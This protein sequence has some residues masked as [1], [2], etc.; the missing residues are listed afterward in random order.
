MLTMTYTNI[1]KCLSVTHYA[2]TSALCCN[3]LWGI[4]GPGHE[5]TVIWLCCSHQAMI[6]SPQEIYHDAWGHFQ[7]SQ[8]KVL[9]S[10]SCIRGH[11]HNKELPHFKC[12]YIQVLD[13]VIH[14]VNLTNT[15]SYYTTVATT[16][17]SCCS[18]H[19]F[20]YHV[21]AFHS[22]VGSL[23]D[24]CPWDFISHVA[25]HLK[26]K[27]LYQ[28]CTMTGLLN[29]A[30]WYIPW[31]VSIS[32]SGLWLDVCFFWGQWVC[33][34]ASFIWELLDCHTWKFIRK[35]CCVTLSRSLDRH[36]CSSYSLNCKELLGNVKLLA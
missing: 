35:M 14:W 27:S 18:V 7:L 4:H 33:W 26:S 22:V 34:L 8:A 16:H 24:S 2:Q 25:S 6:P 19:I 13:T 30:Q 20:L 3:F 31:I 21:R 29:D 10:A 15:H 11:P 1:C 23:Y 17:V 28:G 12:Q 5:D 36:G 32:L 9:K